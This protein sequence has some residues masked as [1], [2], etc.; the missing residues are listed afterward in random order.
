MCIKLIA[1]NTTFSR[2]N[3]CYNAI[4]CQT[5]STDNILLFGTEQVA[6]PV[7]ISIDKLGSD[8]WKLQQIIQLLKDGAVGVIPTDTVL[9]SL[10]IS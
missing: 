1:D 6:E 9:V 8:V 7:Y 3:M 4:C 10:F 5:Y 2:V